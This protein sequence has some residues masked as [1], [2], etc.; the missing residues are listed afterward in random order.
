MG[1]LEAGR[2]TDPLDQDIDPFRAPG[3]AQAQA[4]AAPRPCRPSP[5]PPA[6]AKHLDG[7]R[8]VDRPADASARLNG[9]QDGTTHRLAD[10]VNSCRGVGGRRI[11]SIRGRYAW[12]ELSA[13]LPNG[14]NSACLPGQ[15]V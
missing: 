8:V 12:Q 15:V 1:D 3:L 7:G 14:K 10:P 11:R 2:D 6:I 9:P 13:G 4:V 5:D